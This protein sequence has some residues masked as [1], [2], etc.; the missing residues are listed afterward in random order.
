MTRGGA[1]ALL[2][3][4]LLL[5]LPLVAWVGCLRHKSRP[6]R[7]LGL[8]VGVKSDSTV[9]CAVDDLVPPHDQ[10][11]SDMWDKGTLV[12]PSFDCTCK[13]LKASYH[14]PNLGTDGYPQWMPRQESSGACKSK[15]K[16]ALELDPLPPGSK[17]LLYG[18]S[19]VRQVVEGIVCAY[20]DVIGSRKGSL[21]DVASGER[22]EAKPIDPDRQ[23]RSCALSSKKSERVLLESGCVSEEDLEEACSCDTNES[24]FEFENGA[25]LHYHFAH[26]EENKSIEDALKVQGTELSDY[27]AVMAN[28]GNEP[29][30]EVSETLRTGGRLK[31]AGE[32]QEEF[33][34]QGARFVPVHRM[35][36]TLKYL[37]KGEVEGERHNSHFCLPGPPNEIGVLLLKMV[38]ALRGDVGRQASEDGGSGDED[39][40]WR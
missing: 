11:I 12:P 13:T 10:D 18:N 24:A 22:A 4:V 28:P 36:E 8:E 2:L 26:K 17:V 7:G 16:K 33:W 27:D 38:W 39:G 9:S 25:V 21:F 15:T 37:T 40:M 6:T 35:V 34:N 19:H 30:M 23:C 32:E 14:C 1:T 5:A 20:S 31:E 29:R 3:L